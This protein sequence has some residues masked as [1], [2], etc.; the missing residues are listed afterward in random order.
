[1]YPSRRRPGNK[2]GE[3]MNKNRTEIE[4]LGNVVMEVEYYGRVMDGM[5]EMEWT[6]EV[7]ENAGLPSC[8][9]VCMCYHSYG[10]KSTLQALCT[11]TTL[12]LT[13]T[14][15]PPPP[16][17][18]TTIPTVRLMKCVSMFMLH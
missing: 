13:I 15:P 11:T 6:D 3:Y 5:D 10:K 8:C 17:P 12:R 4:M 2:C 18:L 9:A 1:M 16:P 7:V 14:P